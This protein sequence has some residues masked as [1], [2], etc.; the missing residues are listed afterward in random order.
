VLGLKASATTPG[1]LKDNFNWGWFTGSEVQSIII[2]VGKHGSVQA[3]M[4]L[5]ELRV[6]HLH[7]KEA[8]SRLFQVARSVSKPI[9]T[10]THFL[11]QSHTYF[12]KATPDSG[13][14]WA[15]HIQITTPSVQ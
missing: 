1:Y 13:T 3:G 9:P 4:V 6:L 8:R 7:P 15:K 14:L 10:V 11:Q 2:M 5:E 12:N